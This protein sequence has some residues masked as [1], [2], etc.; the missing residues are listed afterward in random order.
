MTQHVPPQIAED[1]SPGIAL[2][3]GEFI[4]ASQLT[5]GQHSDW[6]CDNNPKCTGTPD[7][8]GCT[9]QQLIERR[10]SVNREGVQFGNCWISHAWMLE[11]RGPVTAKAYREWLNLPE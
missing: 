9:P 5:P 1:D 6:P 3:S 11:G 4:P 2:D 8:P 10:V 7:C